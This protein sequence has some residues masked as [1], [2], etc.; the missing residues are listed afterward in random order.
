LVDEKR[1]KLEL[2]ESLI[3][4]ETLR[5]KDHN[6]IQELKG[7]IRVF[8]RVRPCISDS[9]EA[10]LANIRYFGEDNEKMEL[11]EQISSTLGKTSTR[12]HSFSFDRVFS[13]ES[14]QHDCFEEISQLVQSALDG[15]NVCIFAYGQTGSGKT[16]TMQGPNQPDEE[17]MGMIP[18]AVQQIYNVAQQLKQFGWNYKMEGQ[19]L[20]IYNESINDL[21]GDV[22]SFGKLKHEIH[23]FDNKQSG[24]STTS[25]TDM[26]TVNLDSPSKVKLML[27]RASQNRAT[28]STNLN[29]RSSRSHS[30]FRL[31]LTGKNLENGET[32]NGILN[33]IDLAGSE[34]LS[35]SGSVGDRLRETQA[36]NKSLSCLGDVIQALVNDDTHVPYRNSKLTYLLKNSLGKLGCI[37]IFSCD[38][39]LI[40]CLKKVEIVKL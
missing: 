9:A 35:M 14:T 10:N 31:K 27:K 30:V 38:Y 7:N 16:F 25:V 23:H 37:Y 3:E 29:E 20:E 4:Q 13:P 15:Y 24:T 5:R 2:E 39:I 36:I 12:S 8:C 19:F 1:R 26:T 6:R 40:Y 32:T 33:L 28:G 18:R 11:S 21:L 17:S 34:R 22:S